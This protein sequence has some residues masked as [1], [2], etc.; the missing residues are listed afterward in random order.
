MKIAPL[1]IWVGGE[2]GGAGTIFRSH[3]FMLIQL[4]NARGGKD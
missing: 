1:K 4:W 3:L 2:W